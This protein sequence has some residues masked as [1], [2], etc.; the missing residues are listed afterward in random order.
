MEA[1]VMSAQLATPVSFNGEFTA[2]SFVNAEPDWRAILEKAVSDHP[3][4]KAGVSVRLGV[5]RSYVSRV[6]SHGA[7]AYE[8]PD[9]FITK[10]IERLYMVTECPHTLQPQPFSEC[11]AISLAP[12]PTHNPLRMALWKSC[13][14]CPNKPVKE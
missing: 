6:L 1:E 9:S 11:R 2:G 5:S 12:A 3:K 4:G 13:Q 10:V 8:A 14:R 7:S